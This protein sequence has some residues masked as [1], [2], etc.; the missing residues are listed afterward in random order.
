MKCGKAGK[1]LIVEFE[2]VELKAY[3]DVAGFWTIGVGHL[4]RP[5]ESFTTITRDEAMEL[6]AKDLADAEGCINALSLT[7]TQNEFD[8]LCSFVFNLGCGAF[9]NSTL[10][11]KIKSGED[12]AA[13]FKRWNKAGGKE[14]AG[15]TRRRK[16]EE[17]LFNKTEK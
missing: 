1:D 8:A 17:A 4:I 16:A 9:R 10:L 14:V 5:G 2:G 13:E 15:L 3:K 6:L 12:A 11:K 7:L